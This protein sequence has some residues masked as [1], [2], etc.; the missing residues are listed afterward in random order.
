M[1]NRIKTDKTNQT[2]T[3]EITKDDLE[4][5][6]N[7]LDNMTDKLQRD[8]LENLPA[9]ESDRVRLDDYKELRENIAKILILIRCVY[10]R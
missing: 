10:I 3:L 2:V 1:I 5:I 8:L 9:M 4:K 6:I 7:S